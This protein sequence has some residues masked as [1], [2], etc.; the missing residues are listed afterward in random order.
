MLDFQIVD[1]FAEERFAGNQLAVVLDAA[2]LS[3]QTMQSIAAEFNFS[4]TTF[5]LG[6]SRDAFR[7]RIFTPSAE[8]PFAGHPTLGTACVLRSLHGGHRIVLELDVGEVPVVFEESDDGAIAW[9]TPPSPELGRPS[10]REE[11]A[12]L[13]GLEPSDIEKDLPVCEASVGVRFLMVPVVGLEALRRARLDLTQVQALRERGRDPTGVYLFCRE[14]Y[15]PGRDVACR[16]LWEA[17][18]AR[19]DPATGSACVCLGGYAA[20]HD[21]FG[22]G[23]VDLG[24][25]EFDA[26]VEQG[27][28]VGRPSLLR[29]R[30]RREGETT[31]VSV[32]GRTLPV[33]RGRLQDVGASAE[34][35]AEK[36]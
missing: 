1:V 2:S 29:L 15:E 30:V 3:E 33:A 14:T 11:A 13:I 34:G 20:A 28:E 32:G 7:V 12:A 31:R 18:G 10:S 4:E 23:D 35:S 6:K 36:R 22:G 25:G 24:A 16:M 19:E 9:M 27:I 21:Y 26:L 17:N 8:L 5:V